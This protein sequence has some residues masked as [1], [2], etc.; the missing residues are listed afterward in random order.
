MHQHEYDQNPQKEINEKNGSPILRRI[1]Q[2][3]I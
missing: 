3:G 1:N 2:A